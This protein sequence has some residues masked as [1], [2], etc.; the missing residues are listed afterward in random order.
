MVFGGFWLLVAF[1]Y[2]GVYYES[3]CFELFISGFVAYVL[4]VYGVCGVCIY[5][6]LAV[7]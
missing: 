6:C 3:C 4:D 1:A 5:Y 7:V 2:V